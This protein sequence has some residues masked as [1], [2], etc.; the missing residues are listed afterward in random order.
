MQNIGAVILAAGESSRFGAPKQLAQFRGQTFVRRIADVAEQAGCWP[1]VVVAG[2]DAAKIRAEISSTIVENENWRNG[3][4]S[5]IRTGVEHLMKIEPETAAIVL[6]VCDQ[7]FVD[8][9]V[10]RHLIALREKSGKDI[11]ASSYSGTLGVPALF[12]RSLFSELMSLSGESGAKKI[13]FG[14][15][16]RVAELPL[17]EGNIDIDTRADYENLTRESSIAFH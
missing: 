10:I 15:R 14:N 17:P 8:A 2:S 6:L 9:A 5:S 11:V 12:S 7:P 3:I 16:D 4:G 13:I 1:V